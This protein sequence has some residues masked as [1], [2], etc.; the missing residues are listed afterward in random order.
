MIFRR[1]KVKKIWLTILKGNPAQPKDAT[2]HQKFL[3]IRNFWTWLT[4]IDM[5]QKS[6]GSSHFWRKKAG[7]IGLLSKEV[8]AKIR[9]FADHFFNKQSLNSILIHEKKVQKILLIFCYFGPKK[10]N[11]YRILH[12]PEKF[13]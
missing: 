12:E 7:K 10:D 11:F 4:D 8:I 9:G 3:N 2:S 6:E 13:F 5:S 1:T